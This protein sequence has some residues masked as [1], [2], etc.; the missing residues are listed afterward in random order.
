MPPL[1]SIFIVK[2][3]LSPCALI[4]AMLLQNISD[5]KRVL[6]SLTIIQLSSIINSY[7]LDSYLLRI[8]IIHNQLNVLNCRVFVVAFAEATRCIFLTLISITV[9]SKTWWKIMY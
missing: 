6:N 8:F 9:V 5:Y 2:S 3:T 4:Y 7:N 1:Y